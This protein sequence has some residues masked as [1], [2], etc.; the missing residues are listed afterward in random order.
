MYLRGTGALEL[1]LQPRDETH[2]EIHKQTGYLVTMELM[3]K[4]IDLQS[5]VVYLT[6]RRPAPLSSQKN[7]A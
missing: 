6:K 3:F 2:R 1:N 5:R 7:I 4:Q